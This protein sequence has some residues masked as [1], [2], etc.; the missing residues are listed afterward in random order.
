MLA[1]SD[2]R[3]ARL[4][5]FVEGNT[6]MPEDAKA[7]VLARLAEPLVPARMVARIEDRMGG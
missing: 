5:A 2:E 1:L 4:V 3:R 6:R 7:R